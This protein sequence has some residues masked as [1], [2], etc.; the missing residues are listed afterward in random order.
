MKHFIYLLI[1]FLLSCSTTPKG[2]KNTRLVTELEATTKEIPPPHQLNEQR[3]RQDLE[4]FKKIL[5]S[6]KQLSSSDWALHDKLLNDY[7]KLKKGLNKPNSVFVPAHSRWSKNFESYCLEATKAAPESNEKFYWI[8]GATKTP[9]IKELLQATATRKSLK[10]ED[11]QTIIWNLNNKTNWE[12]YPKEYQN[13]LLSVDPK[14]KDKLPN[15]LKSAIKTKALDTIQDYIPES[16]EQA[17]SFVEGKFYDYQD[18]KASIEN[19]K[20][21][22]ELKVANEAAAIDGT[23][24][25]AKTKSDSFD[26]QQITFYNPTDKDAVVDLSEYYLKPQRSDVQPVGIIQRIL[27]IDPNLLN[28]LEKTLYETMA[29]LGLGHIPV[30][31]D[32]IDLF[33]ASTGKDFFN[34]D[35]LTNEERFLSAMAILAGSG[36]DYR[37]AKK[38]VEAPAWYVRDSQDK[39]RLIKN[40]KGYLKLKDLADSTEGKG[41]PDSWAVKVT[42]DKGGEDKYQGLVFIHPDR[43]DIRIRVMPGNPNSPFPNS[44]QPYVR[45]EI[46]GISYDKDGRVVGKRSEMAHIPLS[47]YKFIEFWGKVGKK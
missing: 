3:I 44:R 45:Q 43:H 24:I 37:Y 18:V 15:E 46:G 6:K 38:I 14:A 40:E 4:K 16:V 25:Y 39:F 35:L 33:E 19:K 22:E 31:G 21:K 9:Y 23:P 8:K 36:Q 12:E 7:I 13:I 17:M 11:I 26:S 47:E 10:Q 28:E 20:S 29:R 5:N 1:L 2:A 30:L 27:S 32:L 41:I 34:N 42:K